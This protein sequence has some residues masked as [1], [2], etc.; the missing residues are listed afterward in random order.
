VES[1]GPETGRWEA[2]KKEGKPKTSAIKVHQ[3][4]KGGRGLGWAKE[5][6][7]KTISPI[8]GVAVEEV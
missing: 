2:E 1:K 7:W 6:Y 3:N 8:Q 4:K 5:G